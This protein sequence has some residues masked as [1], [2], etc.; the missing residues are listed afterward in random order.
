MNVSR[1]SLYLRDTTFRS[2]DWRVETGMLAGITQATDDIC[3]RY[4]VGQTSTE[5]AEHGVADRENKPRGFL[6][7]GIS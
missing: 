2:L 1:I 4:G 6:F 3:K 5:R 7:G